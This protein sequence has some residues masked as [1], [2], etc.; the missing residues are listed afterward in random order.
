MFTGRLLPQ[1]G[2]LPHLPH[3][4]SMVLQ[5]PPEARRCPPSAGP[6]AA[7]S[8]LGALAPCRRC[9]S[10]SRLSF[11]A[12]PPPPCL[13]APPGPGVIF[14]GRPQRT[15]GPH[16]HPAAALLYCSS[17][18]A[19][20]GP[21]APAGCPNTSEAAGRPG[22]GPSR[23]RAIHPC[24]AAARCTTRGHGS[25]R[26][27]TPPVPSPAGWSGSAQKHSPEPRQEPSSS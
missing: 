20:Q 27:D 10:R 19:P 6:P 26:G 17:G 14:A 9:G 15:Q 22:W 8:V 25:N 2:A 18:Q 12:T 24:P 23:S 3:Q 13:R 4:P 11:E 1:A 5:G 7:L 21:W 16:P